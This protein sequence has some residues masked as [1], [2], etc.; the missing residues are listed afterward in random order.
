VIY[1]VLGIWG[2]AALIRC[3]KFPVKLFVRVAV[4]SLV[5][6][7]YLL[8][9]TFVF[10][11]NPVMA[12]WSSQNTLYSPHPLHYVFGYGVLAILA[13]PA[14]RW[15][16]QRG[17]RKI[18]YLLLPAW[19]VAAPILVYL[20]INVQRRLLEGMFVPL[21][22][23][24]VMGLRL[25]WIGLGVGRYPRRARL[26]WREA[27]IAVLIISLASTVTLVLGTALT[28]RT[29]DPG[30]LL[31]HHS[32]AEI[33][34]LDWLNTHAEPDSVVLC[35]LVIGNYLPAR[36]SLRAF[37][38][39]GPETLRLGEKEL[40]VNHFFA[41]QMSADERR[42]LFDANHIRYVF[43][44]PGVGILSMPELS[45][46]YNQDGYMIYEVGNR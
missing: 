29:S 37:I 9:N 43:V 20:P 15:G 41:G 36:T 13:L 3:R 19:V 16:W 27:V 32:T 12:E 10:V 14:I 2:V 30:N 24:A 17:R 6:L 28:A 44:E 42:A 45:L 11:T 31:S 8:Y 38:G 22:I 40:L 4:G 18:A 25:W 35:S 34:A 21:C 39:H 23:L 46:L 5:P 33:A 7:P 26:I 1:F